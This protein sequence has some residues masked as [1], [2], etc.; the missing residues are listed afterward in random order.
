MSTLAVAKRDFLDVWR[1]KLV[2]APVALVVPLIALVAAYLSIAGE[3][4]SGSIKFTLGAPVDRSAVVLGKLLSRSGVVLAGLG[5]SFVIGT[6][7]A[8]VLVPEMTFEYA[9]YAIFIGVTLL[10]ALAYVAVAVAISAATVSG[11][12]R[13]PA[14][15]ASS[16]CSISSGT[17]C[18][19]ARRRCSSSYLRNS[20]G[21][22]TTTSTSSN[23]R[24]PRRL[25]R[26]PAGTGLLAVRART[27]RVIIFN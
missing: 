11:R 15:S 13:W 12:R 2:W 18:R 24:H 4:E 10:Y 23:D 17:S 26:R 9:D 20:G 22:P 16:S 3:R 21:I 6:G 8:Q 19:S 5:V 7:I 27:T 14:G 1:A 25:G